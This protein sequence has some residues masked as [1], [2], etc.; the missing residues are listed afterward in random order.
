MSMNLKFS[1]SSQNQLGLYEPDIRY[2]HLV[3]IFVF[4]YFELEAVIFFKR[5]YY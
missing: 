1:N 5:E 2:P 4:E 3:I